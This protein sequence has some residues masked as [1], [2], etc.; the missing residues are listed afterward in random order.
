MRTKKSL[1]NIVD[2]AIILVLIAIIIGSFVRSR[3]SSMFFGNDSSFDVTYTILIENADTNIRGNL[4]KGDVL[5]LESS[6]KQAGVI[7]GIRK[8]PSKT[9]IEDNDN[10]EMVIKY[11][12]SRHDLTLTISAKAYKNDNG[13]FICDSYFIAP[14]KTIK[15]Y[16]QLCSLEGK[17]TSVNISQ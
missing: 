13:T 4:D 1:F 11:D 12:S 5:Y 16:T 2:T 7:S 9:Y 3:Q 6:S 14:G 8:S 17:I 10:A 15:A